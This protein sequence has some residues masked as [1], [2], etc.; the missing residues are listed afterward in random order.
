VAKNQ[1]RWLARLKPMVGNSI[2]EL[3]RVPLS[4]DVWGLGLPQQ[5]MSRFTK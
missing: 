5:R 1:T 2:N 4:L 3:L